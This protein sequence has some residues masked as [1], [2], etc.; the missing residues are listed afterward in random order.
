MYLDAEGIGAITKRT[1]A[2]LSDSLGD[3]SLD[4][5]LT[6]A[7]VDLNVSSKLTHRLSEDLDSVTRGA[8]IRGVGVGAFVQWRGDKQIENAYVITTLGDFAKL[9]RGDHLS[10]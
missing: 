7:G 9:V 8:K 1:P 2:G 5:D 6:L 3:D 4:P 10:P